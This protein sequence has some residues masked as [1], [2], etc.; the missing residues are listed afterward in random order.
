MDL[1]DLNEG[2]FLTLLSTILCVAGCCILFVDNVYA[3]IMPRSITRRYRFKL[4]ENYAFMNASLSF[5]AGCLT[6]T[7]LYRLLPEGKLYLKKACS[8]S[9]DERCGNAQKLLLNLFVSFAAGMLICL[10]LNALL[11]LVTSN[12]VVHCKHSGDEQSQLAGVHHHGHHTG[13]T[14]DVDG[15]HLHLHS[16]IQDPLALPSAD[17]TVPLIPRL[18]KSKS[19]LHYFTNTDDVGECKGYTSADVYLFHNP[20][21]D[22]DE[23]G[24]FVIPCPTDLTKTLAASLVQ[25]GGGVGGHLLSQNDIHHTRSHGSLVFAHDPERPY[26]DAFDTNAQHYNHHQDHHHHVLTPLSHLLLIGIETSMA[27]TLHKVPEGFITYVTSETN[28]TLGLL[29]FLSLMLHNFTEGFLMC[30]PLYYLMAASSPQ[31]AK[32]KA[33]AI[34]ATLGGLSQPLGAL[35]GMAFLKFNQK[36][37]IDLVELN[38]IFGVTMAAT[39]GFLT[40]V[41]LQMFS[42]AIMFNRG[43]LN[44]V[45]F[46]CL[47]G[48][49]LIGFSSVLTANMN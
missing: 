38:F 10:L 32:V 3:L 46:W 36:Q 19:L 49:S 20:A 24:E 11:H 39:S 5:S 13:N 29:I 40:V 18:K 25:K 37:T 22:Q 8:K 12:S 21:A 47:A 14:G 44:Y 26:D 4:Q 9:D 30:L 17:E 16:H 2:W 33:F 35:C 43:S 45:L 48:M 41:G 34:G 28:K 6:F 15:Q 23:L 27:I 7:A 31:F 42:L 1:T